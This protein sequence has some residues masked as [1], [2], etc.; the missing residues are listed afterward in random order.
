MVVD[1]SA[2]LSIYY[3]EDDAALMLEKMSTADRL[4][5]SAATV[6]EVV[7]AAIRRS[8][9]EGAAN[10]ERL[11]RALRIEIVPFDEAQSLIAREA[12]LKFGKGLGTSAKLNLGDCFS[13]ALAKHLNQPLLFKGNDFSQTDVVQA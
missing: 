13:Y 2:V 12:Y 4:F 5:I 8:G 6:V 10:L 11:M 1:S 3:S 9:A 7:S